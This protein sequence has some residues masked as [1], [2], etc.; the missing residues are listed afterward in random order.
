MKKYA[1][2]VN[3]LMNAN[4]QL[5][6]GAY[7]QQ[8]QNMLANILT[9]S[10][11]AMIDLMLNSPSGALSFNAKLGLKPGAPA[12]ITLPDIISNASAENNMRIAAPLLTNIVSQ[13]FSTVY[14][15]LANIM[16]AKMAAQPA[17]A[18]AYA[19]L[20]AI[21]TT[22]QISDKAKNEIASWVQQGLL[23][24]DQ[25]DYTMNVTADGPTIKINGK[26]LSSVM[27]PSGMPGS[28]MPMPAT[29]T[30]PATMSPPASPMPGMIMTPLPSAPATAPIPAKP[31]ITTSTSGNT[32]AM[33]SSTMQGL[34]MPMANRPAVTTAP[35][36]P[37]ETVP[38][39]SVPVSM[40]AAMPAM[41]IVSMPMNPSILTPDV[42]VYPAADP[43][44]VPDEIWG[45][46]P[47]FMPAPEQQ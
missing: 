44:S 42:Q 27:S 35:P 13:G 40:P 39:Y 14:T 17:Q 29:S 7:E 43:G 8:M 3:G 46:V 20:L 1:D 22:Q 47:I 36:V 19:N 16:K 25:N 18:A 33:P 34:S 5:Q 4:N 32:A 24:A 23:V 41:P 9:P 38:A 26:D 12:T 37:S 11:N 45:P 21:P 2:F 10:S 28:V 30:L 31:S 15:Q 6:P